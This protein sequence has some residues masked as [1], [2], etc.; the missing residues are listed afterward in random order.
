MPAPLALVIDA[1]SILA[2]CK[3]DESS[4]DEEAAIEGMQ[5]IAPFTVRGELINA[6]ANAVR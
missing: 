1:S 5:L 6:L 2:I 3:A 4:K